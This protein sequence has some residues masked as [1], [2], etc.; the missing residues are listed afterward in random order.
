MG[1][2]LAKDLKI[3][4]NLDGSMSY[5][6]R[7]LLPYVLEWIDT[8]DLFL[9]KTHTLTSTTIKNI[10]LISY[11]VN[12]TK[13]DVESLDKIVKYV[14]RENKSLYIYEC[15]FIAVSKDFKQASSKLSTLETSMTNLV[16]HGKDLGSFIFSYPKVHNLT[17]T[18]GSHRNSI[19]MVL[20]HG[21]LYFIFGDADSSKVTSHG[22]DV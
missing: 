5:K 1:A 18:L 10:Y 4:V 2:I 20:Y 22:Y 7:K 17:D 12:H 6:R 16:N 3:H 9:I 21:N 11:G 19:Y 14:N 8:G 15:Q 13:G